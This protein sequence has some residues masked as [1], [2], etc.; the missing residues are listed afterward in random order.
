MT[1]WRFR[2]SDSIVL[3]SLGEEAASDMEWPS[4][5]DQ[6]VLAF[7]AAAPAGPVLCWFLAVEVAGPILYVHRRVDDTWEEESHRIPGR[8]PQDVVDAMPDLW[9]A[10]AG[11]AVEIDAPDLP[12]SMLLPVLRIVP[13][14]S[15][16]A[17]MWPDAE[18]DR[19]LDPDEL[20]AS[21][22]PDLPI[23]DRWVRVN[24]RRVVAVEFE[25]PS[26][27]RLVPVLVDEDGEVF[28]GT[29][30]IAQ[31]TSYSEGPGPVSWDHTESIDVIAD[32]V[33]L[34]RLR[35]DW[36]SGTTIVEL[37]ATPRELA[38][39]VA[40]WVVAGSFEG[41]AALAL[42]PLDPGETLTPKGREEWEARTELVEYTGCWFDLPEAVEA[43]L[44]ARLTEVSVEYRMVRK[45]LAAPRSAVGK[46]LARSLDD[47]EDARH[48]W[49]VNVGEF[50]KPAGPAS[51][52][53]QKVD[54]HGPTVGSEPTPPAVASQVLPALSTGA[55]VW[56]SRS[57]V[58]VGDDN[59]YWLDPDARIDIV[60]L[61]SLDVRITKSADGSLVM[62]A[63]ERA[64]ARPWGS[65]PAGGAA[66]RI[67]LR[68]AP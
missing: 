47:A 45:G 28:D 13:G 68:V 55:S 15:E 35:S 11:T 61:P 53:G 42:E 26:S 22:Y 56:V 51:S 2:R 66:S 12:A 39:L 62:T 50:W 14:P 18:A 9:D 60:G 27:T 38:E 32:G 5:P 65:G 24:G 1:Q 3:P 33:G 4:P 41:A 20:L 16:D 34:I 59:T 64:D 57:A 29:R 46:A 43:E 31:F 40:D 37:P 25:T 44:R 67:E 49:G 17:A 36:G 52:P 58:S 7:R 30:T 63:N 21:S 23:V 10:A 8:D 6:T 48:T 54:V 19:W